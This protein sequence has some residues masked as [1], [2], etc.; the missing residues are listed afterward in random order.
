MDSHFCGWYFKCQSPT[1]T[2]ALIPAVHTHRGRRTCSIQIVEEEEH[3]NFPLSG[4]GNIY[5]DSPRAKLGTNCFSP[6]GITLNLRSEPCRAV[7]QLQFGP[8]TPLPRD[9][10]GPFRFVPFLECRH[11]VFSMRHQV[12]GQLRVNGRLYHF[13]HDLGYMEGDR[14]CS[15]PRRYAWTQCLFPDGS[16]MLSVADIPFG[17]FSFP[18]VIA[19]LS[20]YGNVIVLATYC[21]ARILSVQ[22]GKISVKQKNLLL[23]AELLSDPGRPL[24]AP[25]QGEMSRTIRENLSCHARYRL[26]D[27]D[28]LIW[29][30]ESH[31]ASFEYEYP[32]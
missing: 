2:L 23:M 13:D 17:P 6:Q 8:P 12:T 32:S 25:Q 14:G 5:W 20:F 22:S 26:Y 31:Q 30:G 28:R 10:M 29:A 7:G 27:G 4:E 16:L 19:A 1:Q 24:R 18:G 3:W 21:G 9:I 15:F 11:R